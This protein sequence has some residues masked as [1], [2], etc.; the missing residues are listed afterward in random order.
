ME[1]IKSVKNDSIKDFNKRFSYELIL[2]EIE[3]N[4][5][6]C[7][8]VN[9]AI[10]EVALLRSFLK[11]IGKK[12][13]FTLG[14]SGTH[15]TGNPSKQNFV[16]NESYNWVRNQLKEYARQNMT[17][18]THIHIGLTN[19][20]DI[21]QITNALR[22]WI[23]PLFALSINSP[24]F[25]GLNTGMFSSRYFQFGNFPRTNIPHYLHS[26]DDYITLI[27]SLKDAN[28]ISKHRHIWWKIRPHI[29]FGTIEFRMFDA[30][31]SL[32]NVRTLAAISQA[33]VHKIYNEI[34]NGK[35]IPDYNLE[36]LND[37]L[38]KVARFG[39]EGTI[40]NPITQKPEKMKDYIYRMIDYV[41]SSL[42][43]FNNE[44]AKK[45][46]VT[47]L[48]NNTEAEQQLDIYNKSDI[49]KLKMF[50]IDNVQY[51]V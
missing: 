22:C 29:D 20:N 50:L 34:K 10:H 16:K 24:F 17:F 51:D 47:I 27:N 8:D 14:I 32:K 25:N 28:S 7:D 4:T 18:S 37:A 41:D 36:F 35:K 3:S 15:P 13:D 1:H 49:N 6:P 31:R 33:L 40:I 43:Y 19:G 38:W 5:S 48:D 21:I 9:T 11:K 26:M 39:L 44:F 23:A 2:S 42:L 12:F 30:Q 46:V 45:N